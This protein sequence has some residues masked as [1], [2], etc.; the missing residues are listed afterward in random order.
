MCCRSRRLEPSF[1]EL[2]AA[3]LLGT[4]GRA[5]SPVRS[6]LPLALFA[7]LGG[8]AAIG[9]LLRSRRVGCCRW[10]GAWGRRLCAPLERFLAR[11]S[12]ACARQ[13]RRG[14]SAF[15]SAALMPSCRLRRFMQSCERHSGGSSGLNC[16]SSR[17]WSRLAPRPDRDYTKRVARLGQRLLFA[18]LWP[19]W[20]DVE[21]ARQGPAASLTNSAVRPSCRR[22]SRTAHSLS[23]PH[24]A[25]RASSVQAVPHSPSTDHVPPVPQAPPPAARRRLVRLVLL[26]NLSRWVISPPRPAR[27]LLGPALL[28]SIRSLQL[29]PDRVRR[30]GQSPG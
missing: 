10:R 4:A 22:A 14:R 27:R 16:F 13:R 1:V 7:I 11:S 3:A 15:F 5:G 25:L 20:S 8:F 19:R 12:R 28:A 18:R 26:V 29:D 21:Q 23:P 6:S 17:G 24:A 30:T 2:L 9:R